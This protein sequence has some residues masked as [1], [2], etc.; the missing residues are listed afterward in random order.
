[1]KNCGI[2]IL[3]KEDCMT[4]HTAVKRLQRL[5]GADIAGHTGTLD[6]AA[7]GVLPVLLGRGV[8]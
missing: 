1:M 4:S 7:T 5:L 8:K 3:H 2:F 6:H